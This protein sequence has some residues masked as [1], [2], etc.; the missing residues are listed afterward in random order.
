MSKK[1]KD[2]FE[3]NI[4]SETENFAIWRSPD[5]DGYLYHLELG[6]ITLH[7]AGDEFEE[8]MVLLNGIISE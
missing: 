2:D 8:L 7:L 3:M 5:D 6:S 4:L 1:E